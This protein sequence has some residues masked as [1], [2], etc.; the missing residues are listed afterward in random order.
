MRLLSPL[1][2][3][4]LNSGS[5]SNVSPTTGQTEDV[6]TL[7]NLSGSP[8]Q[9]DPPS[10]LLVIFLQSCSSILQDTKMDNPTLYDTTKVRFVYI[11]F[12]YYILI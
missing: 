4:N 3:A 11:M 6:N 9:I 10:N 12:F 7:S 2:A 1:S 8:L 5:V